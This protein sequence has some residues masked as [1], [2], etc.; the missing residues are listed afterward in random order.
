MVGYSGNRP[1]EVVRVIAQAT[2]GWIIRELD[3]M[4]R[5]D[6]DWKVGDF[7]GLNGGRWFAISSLDDEKVSATITEIKDKAND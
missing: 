3:L 2:N 1:G 7:I 5:E 6:R 4:P